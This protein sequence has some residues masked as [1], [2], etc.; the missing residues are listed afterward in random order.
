MWP[1][2]RR[3]ITCV[4]AHFF[5]AVE[6]RRAWT[7][8]FSG[9]SCGGGCATRRGMGRATETKQRWAGCTQRANPI[10]SIPAIVPLIQATLVRGASVLDTP[11]RPV[12]SLLACF[13]R[14]LL[15]PCLPAIC[16]LRQNFSNTLDIIFSPLTDPAYS[17]NL[18]RRRGDTVRSNV[19]I[20][21]R[22]TN[23]EFLGRLPRRVCTH[24]G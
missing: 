11:A 17:N 3:S 19:S 23:T 20:Q 12:H 6:S 18:D 22:K 4:E 13:L 8:R 9:H 1:Q 24:T 21:T 2:V 7:N 15:I 5:N 10:L 14:L 16:Y